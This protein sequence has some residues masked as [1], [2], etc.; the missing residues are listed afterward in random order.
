MT[1]LKGSHMHIVSGVDFIRGI[2]IVSIHLLFMITCS[3][4][5]AVHIANIHFLIL[6]LGHRILW[7]MPHSDDTNEVKG[8]WNHGFT[9][10][11]TGP[12]SPSWITVTEHRISQS[13][14]LTRVMF[15]RGNVTEK[16]RFGALV[17]PG[18]R[19]LDM[20]AGIGYYTLPALI[21]GKARHVTAC[22][23]NPNAIYALRYNL[24]ANG[25]D[26]K[27]TVLEGDCRVSLKEHLQSTSMED[28]GYD[29]ISLGLL[30]SSE[31]GWVVA[32]S[33]LRQDSGGWMH[34]HANV[35]TVEREH[36]THWLCHSLQQIAEKNGHKDWHVICTNVEMV[37]SFAPKVDH[38]VADVFVGPSSSPKLP[39]TEEGACF[40]STAGVELT[41][42]VA[43]S[44]ALSKDGIL[45]QDW[46]IEQT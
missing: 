13:F 25:V 6:Y 22:E 37:K 1:R 15:S 14:D 5:S 28:Y 11:S 43:P 18:D 44:C 9:P 36:W 20:Y 34:V 3:I 17:Q 8:D 40:Y 29:R 32:V 35:P 24:K 46:M 30:P 26:D 4:C 23:W 16:K 27:V 33:C 41:A 38:V 10:T 2:C 21:H 19:V 42:D 12:S 39:M 31:G 7:P 45:Y